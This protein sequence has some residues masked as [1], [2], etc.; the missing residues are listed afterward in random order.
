MYAGVGPGAKG[1]FRNASIFVFHPGPKTFVGASLW[2]FTNI[3]LSS[4]SL[5]VSNKYGFSCASRKP[6]VAVASL[7]ATGATGSVLSD[8]LCV[9]SAAGA[10]AGEL[11][12]AS[13]V[14]A[15]LNSPSFPWFCT[16]FCANPAAH[17][18]K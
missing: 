18:A 5:Y 15:P 6:G 2:G 1:L 17:V 13:T 3:L 9:G 4:F 8:V 11:L 12:R 14:A 16:E 10:G 7:L